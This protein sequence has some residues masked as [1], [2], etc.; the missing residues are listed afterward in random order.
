MVSALGEASESA[1]AA[2]ASAPASLHALCNLSSNDV[3][4]AWVAIWVLTLQVVTGIDVI[5]TYGP[6]VFEQA[7]FSSPL[8]A[9]LLVRP[10]QQNAREEREERLA[11]RRRPSTPLSL[12]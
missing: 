12:L 2:A 7:G 6:T 1:A 9:Q 5:V 3:H 11:Q 10:V 8:L 4:Q